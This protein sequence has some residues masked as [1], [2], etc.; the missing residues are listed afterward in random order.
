MLT[1]DPQQRCSTQQIM[2]HS[3]FC[4]ALPPGV[5]GFN[6]QLAA[7]PNTTPQSEADIVDVFNQVCPAL[8]LSTQA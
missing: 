1:V 2:A 7:A 3:W 8:A 5:Q 6:A 4:E